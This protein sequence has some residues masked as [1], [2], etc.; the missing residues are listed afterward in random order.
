MSESSTTTTRTALHTAPW[1]MR[2]PT[3]PN[4]L[5]AAA[6]DTLLLTL[7]N[8]AG[9]IMLSSLVLACQ[10]LQEASVG[11]MG[12]LAR[13]AKTEIDGIQM[14]G[15]RLEGIL[16]DD[17]ENGL[18]RTDKVLASA[19]ASWIHQDL[20]PVLDGMARLLSRSMRGQRAQEM[21][22]AQIASAVQ[23][24]LLQLIA[25]ACVSEGWLRPIAAVPWHT[26]FDPTIHR[27][28]ATERIAGM[29]DL[30][31]D[32]VRVGR[33]KIDGT[34]IEPAHVVVAVG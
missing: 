20:Q 22:A 13:D 28:V 7:Q 27:S 33:R 11:L 9:G 15:M 1:Q 2:A 8:R 23:K 5:H 29:S 30:V 17:D 21:G 16:L 24:S 3:E 26:T 6:S 10:L 4:A 34:L 12:T 19:I 18:P 14:R 31:V 25:E 32:L